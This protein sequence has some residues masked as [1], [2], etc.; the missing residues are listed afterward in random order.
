MHADSELLIIFHLFILSFFSRFQ[1]FLYFEPAQLMI[2]YDD[3]ASF[4]AKGQFIK[5]NGL[6]GFAMYVSE[7]F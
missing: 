4:A 1:P 7:H 3:P 5:D 6:A 2:A